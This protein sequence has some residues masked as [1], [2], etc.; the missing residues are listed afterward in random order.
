MKS[1]G[2][3]CSQARVVESDIQEK[4]ADFV[5]FYHMTVCRSK[6]QLAKKVFCLCIQEVHKNTLCLIKHIISEWP[7]KTTDTA[8]VDYAQVFMQKAIQKCA[9][10]FVW[11]HCKQISASPFSSYVLFGIVACKLISLPL[12]KLYINVNLINRIIL[13]KCLFS[14]LSVCIKITKHFD[15]IFSMIYSMLLVF[16]FLFC[17]TC[18][19]SK[20][21]GKNAFSADASNNNIYLLACIYYFKG[22]AWYCCWDLLCFCPASF[23]LLQYY[24]DF[25]FQEQEAQE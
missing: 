14:L 7:D 3:D 1:F 12:P 15:F 18:T 16:V 11:V 20:M 5:E 21:R 22:S 23:L 6:R 19:Q 17:I 4:L 9:N 24:Q 8:Q 13:S 25:V 10:G 2:V